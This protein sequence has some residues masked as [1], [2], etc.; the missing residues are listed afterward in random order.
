MSPTNY[1]PL[2]IALVD[3]ANLQWMGGLTYRQNLLEAICQYAPQT[4]VYLLTQPN[5]DETVENAGYK[6]INYPGVNS[7]FSGLINRATVRLF[8][9]D[10]LLRQ[11]LRAVPGGGV[12][13]IFPGRYTIGKRTAVLC[14]IPDFQFL[15]L[16][17]MYTKA[18]VKDLNTKYKHWSRSATLV[19]LSSQ[20]AREDYSKFIPQYAHK[21]RVMNFVAH[22]PPQLYDTDPVSVTAQYNLPEK[23]IYIPNQFWKHKNHTLVLEALRVLKDRNIRPFVVFSGNTIDIRHPLFFS[24]LLQKVSRWGLRDQV[25]F[26]G[27]APHDHVYSLIRQ[28][29]CVLN[30]SLFE[31]WSTT[32]EE[33]KS[34]GKRVLLS[35]LAVHREQ[36]APS[37]CYFDPRDAGD[38][39]SK[40]EGIWANT[41]PGPDI[42]LEQKARSVAPQRME[43]FAETFLSIA[44]ESVDLARGRGL[45][46]DPAALE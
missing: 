38:L 18:Q 12:D 17:E 20:N 29:I 33:A 27:L 35:D 42:E 15:H 24:E 22:T 21:A 39:A 16:P 26:L 7:K 30:P 45:P 1:R 40:V 10:F 19:V 11:A 32:V 37:A 4:Q 5:R 3:P 44:C 8:G 28:S 9:Y 43:I 13:L 31:G 2:R 25:A 46:G 14:W 6:V 23:F 34:T 41:P 36:D